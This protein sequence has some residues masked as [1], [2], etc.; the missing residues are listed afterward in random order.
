VR[1]CL[2]WS[3]A[4]AVMMAGTADAQREWLVTVTPTLNPLPMGFCGS[5]LITAFDGQDVARNPLGYRISMTDFDMTVSGASVAGHY[6]D[7]SHWEV[8]ACQG[9]TAGTMGTIVASYPAQALAE[10]ARVPGLAFQRTAPFTLAPP[11]GPNNPPGC[12][13]TAPPTPI[14]LEAS[15]RVPVAPPYAPGPVAVTLGLSANGSWYEPSPVSM[16]LALS[17][18]AYRAQRRR[19]LVCHSR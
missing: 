1:A 14:K 2:A 19:R 15:T 10:N 3:C 17:A 11:K 5:V 8:C 12:A 6:I 7:S 16:N 4:I 9:G 13:A 18:Q